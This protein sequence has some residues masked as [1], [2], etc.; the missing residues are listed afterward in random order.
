[1]SFKKK[2][3]ILPLST[4]T[5]ISR[6]QL[7]SG[8]MPV[9]VVKAKFSFLLIYQYLNF[10]GGYCLSFDSVTRNITRFIYLKTLVDIT[11]CIYIIDQGI[12]G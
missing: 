9:V 5:I 1:M 7:T 12:D 11:S 10:A 6:Q 4:C 8:C 2:S 3:L